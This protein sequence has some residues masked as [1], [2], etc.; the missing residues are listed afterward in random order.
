MGRIRCTWP[1]KQRSMKSVRCTGVRWSYWCIYMADI[2]EAINVDGENLANLRLA[3]N[4]ALFNEKTKQMGKH[5]NSLSSV[6]LKFGHKYS[7]EKQNTRQT[8]QTVKKKIQVPPANHTFQRHYKRRNLCQDQ[9]S[10]E[11][12]WKKRIKYSKIDNSPYH[13]KTNTWPMCLANN[14]LWLPSMGSQ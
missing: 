7:R 9:S 3:D 13:S 1:W 11:L 6:S 12:F 4:V 5:L 14:D 10:M 2:S 8:V